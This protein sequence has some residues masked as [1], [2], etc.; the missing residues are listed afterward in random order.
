MVF[1]I[2]M[3]EGIRI[4]TG[5]RRGES[6]EFLF[7][8]SYTSYHW[9]ERG[10]GNVVFVNVNILNRKEKRENN[11]L[12]RDLYLDIKL[13]IGR[14]H[15]GVEMKNHELQFFVHENKPTKLAYLVALVENQLKAFI[16][17]CIMTS[18][19]SLHDIV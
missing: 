13:H 12:A 7:I 15:P 2:P 5:F 19:I 14:Y 1:I 16:H 18:R 17:H 9:Y 4:E 11:K 8:I 6:R 10:K 3:L